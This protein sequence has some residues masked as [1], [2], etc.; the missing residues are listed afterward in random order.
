[1]GDSPKSMEKGGESMQEL[2]ALWKIIEKTATLL[3]V[4][5]SVLAILDHYKR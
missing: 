5:A 1:M 4:W 3:A 2:E